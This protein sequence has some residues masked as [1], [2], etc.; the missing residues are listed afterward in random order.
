MQKM[1]RDTK[2]FQLAIQ[3]IENFIYRSAH[4]FQANP[5]V[6]DHK[7]SLPQPPK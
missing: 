2:E 5:R 3:F 6:T 7:I 4:S 1:S